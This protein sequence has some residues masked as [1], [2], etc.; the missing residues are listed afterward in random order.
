[1]GNSETSNDYLL[2]EDGHLGLAIFHVKLLFLIMHKARFFLFK[3]L[4][5]RQGLNLD[6]R[7]LV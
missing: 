4:L 7:L 1:M 5:L 3:T 6:F 2:S